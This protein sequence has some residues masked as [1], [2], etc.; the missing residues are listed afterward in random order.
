[1]FF[2]FPKHRMKFLLEDFSAKLGRVNIF[3]PTI[4]NKSLHQDN[5]DD[6][7]RIVNFATSKYLVKST[8]FLHRNIHKYTWTSP[9]SKT[10]NRIGHIL[11][12]R[13][14]QSIVL[15]VRSFRRADCDTDHCLVVEN[16]RER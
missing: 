15:D 14:W 12:D 2:Y 6:G 13:K 9:D 10:H 16:F 8:M 11:I 7:V 5:N 3:K 4:G 1:V